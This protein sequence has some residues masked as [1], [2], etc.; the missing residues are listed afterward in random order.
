MNRFEQGLF[1]WCSADFHGILM[2][3]QKILKGSRR[4]WWDSKYFDEIPKL[5][6]NQVTRDYKFPNPS[7]DRKLCYHYSMI[8]STPSNTIS[9]SK[10]IP[11]KTVCQEEQLQ[12]KQKKN[13]TK[14]NIFTVWP[15]YKRIHW[16]IST[17]PVHV[18]RICEKHCKT[19][20]WISNQ[21]I[22]ISLGVSV[23]DNTPGFLIDVTTVTQFL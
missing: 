1:S 21:K 10:G 3:F 8:R 5:P 16:E 17:D 23:F 20:D 12:I 7:A 22:K 13:E 14:Q 15:V 18:R 19:I 9:L 11:M 4:F 6:S 2:R